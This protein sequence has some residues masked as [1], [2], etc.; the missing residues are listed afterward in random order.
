[1]VKKKVGITGKRGFIGSHLSNYLQLQEDVEIIDF[2]RSFF[3]NEEALKKFVSQC[4]TIVHLAAINRHEDLNELHDININLVQSLITAC[5]ASD[6]N[7]HI[8]FSSSTQEKKENL[9]GASKSK[10]ADLFLDWAS[11]NN[12]VCS[13]LIIPGVFG[14]FGRPFYNSVVATFCHQVANGEKPEIIN[15]ASIDLIY[16]NELID[17]ILDLIRLP[18]HGKIEVIPRYNLKVSELKNKLESFNSIY[19]VNNEFPNLENNFDLAL[20]NTFLCFLST[21]FYP[22]PLVKHEDQRGYFMEITRANSKGQFSISTTK[23]GITRGNHFHTRKAER[24]AVVKG[25]ARIALRKVDEEE[26]QEYFLSGESPSYVDMP[27]W[28]TH[29]I[30]NVG[31]EELITLFWINEAYNPDNPD[32]YFVN[33]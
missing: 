33:V 17:D 26:V 12:G 13:S 24:F 10:G 31:D 3:S 2:D 21:D 11:H 1:M 19:V 18:K 6:S 25:K 29:N 23:P 22:R 32:T 5:M 20:F 30:T 4:D 14:P 8:I 9:Y 7:P 15:D 27:I 28:H 16:I